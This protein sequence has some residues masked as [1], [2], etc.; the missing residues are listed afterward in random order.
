M[1]GSPAT[2]T[3]PAELKRLTEVQQFVCRTAQSMGATPVLCPKLELVME[4]IFVNI[5]NHGRPKVKPD[6]EIVCSREE[7]DGAERLRVSFRDWGP[8]FNPLDKESPSLEQ[9]VELRPIG[10]LGIHLVLRMADH[11]EYSRLE[12]GNL[13]TVCFALQPTGT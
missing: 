10:G 12:D 4:E 8:P 2:L 11:C 9:D 7:V 5:V 1:S 6:V 3:I 13:F